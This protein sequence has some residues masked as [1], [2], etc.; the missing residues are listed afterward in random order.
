M[1][2]IL[3]FVS[4]WLLWSLPTYANQQAIDQLINKL[5]PH[6]NLGM[7]VVDLST[8]EILYSRNANHLFIPASNMKLFSEAA[9]LMTLGP[10]YR[11]E[12]QLST[13]ATQIHQGV[14]KGNIFIHLTGD[15]SFNR[16]NLN[17]LLSALK[18]WNVTAIEG[19]VIIDSSL[20]YVSAYPPGWLTSDLAYSYGAPVAPLMLDSNRLVVT[21]NPGSHAGDPAVVEVDDGGSGIPVTNQAKTQANAKGCGVGLS[22]D[23]N[24][25]LTVS[26]CVGLGQW[27]VQQQIAIKNPL[28]YAQGMIK[29]EL[30]KLNIQLTGLVQLGKAPTGSLIIATEY[31]RPI[32]QLMADT[33]K[34][35]DNL[36]ADSLY[37]HAAAKLKGSFVAWKE[38]QP[39]IKH[40][41]QTQTGIQLNN[42]VFTDGSGLSRYNL[43]TP[44][45]TIGLLK[46]LYERFPLSYE[47]IATLPVSGRDGTLQKRFKIPGQEGFVRAK[48]GT[49]TGMN[50]LSGYLYTTNGHTLAFAM[51][52]N[53][54]P[55]KAAGPG[56]PLLDALVTHFLKETSDSMRLVKFF[57]NHN[58]TNFQSPTT[59]AEVQ[60]KHQAKWR[61]LESMIKLALKGQMVN[62]LYRGNELIINDNQADAKKVWS[63]LQSVNK[64]FPF[65]VALISQNS[66]IASTGL[67]RLTW[68]QQNASNF[69]QRQWVLREATPS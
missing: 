38:A 1:K 18:N 2:R 61:R 24:N 28:N 37:L 67:P 49:M 56:R 58:R 39:I 3:V 8:G 53:R 55:G 44:E 32:F 45:Q 47:Y 40:F 62:V 30:K 59:E 50:S 22:L 52:I 63:S 43:V 6:V 33:L 9:V 51:Y 5:N 34:P 36:Y 54:I 14:L 46:F 25:H 65:A 35:S 15:P 31:S 69:A 13:N 29:N 20:A 48:T 21:V 16:N 10:D 12:N 57:N 42:A 41:L 19:N 68:I 23:S 60:K 64:R 27:A 4:L 11:L 66:S 17:H 26:G 7:E